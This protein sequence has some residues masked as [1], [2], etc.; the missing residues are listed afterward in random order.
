MVNNCACSLSEGKHRFGKDLAFSGCEKVSTVTHVLWE[1]GLQ[2][3]DL[4]LHFILKWADF[5]STYRH[6]ISFVCDRELHLSMQT[7][8]LKDK[9][10]MS[11]ISLEKTF[12]MSPQVLLV[13]NHTVGLLTTIFSI[14]AS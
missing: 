8:P 9:S 4:C 2:L 11:C 5:Q 1:E 6:L 13:C 10:C 14:I 7:F 3:Q 12:L